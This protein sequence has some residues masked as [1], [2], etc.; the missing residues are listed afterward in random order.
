MSTNIPDGRRL[1][2]VLQQHLDGHARRTEHWALVAIGP[3]TREADVFQMSGNMESFHFEAIRVPNVL[4]VAAICGGYPL[5]YVA[6]DAMER[7]H[8][9]LAA[10][11]VVLHDWEWDC[12]DWVVEAVRAL[13][14]EKGEWVSMNEGFSEA[15][16][17]R[18][19]RAE[20]DL[21]EIGED[22]LFERMLNAQNAS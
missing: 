12:Q 18:E 1:L 6:E 7:L 11:R 17:R 20:K 3:R 4:K 16:L 13:R 14:Q 15:T 9:M 22:H 5:G 19:L 2:L 10:Q 8:A 21:W